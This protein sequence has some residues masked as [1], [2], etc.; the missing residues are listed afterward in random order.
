VTPGKSVIALPVALLGASPLPRQFQL[1]PPPGTVP[2]P[3]H[4]ADFQNA[5]KVQVNLDGVV[6][7]SGQ[8]VGPNSGKAYEE[9]V[10][11]TTVPAHVASTVLAM[12]ESGEAIR[13]VVAWLEEN[14]KPRV[15]DRS[16]QVTARTAKILLAD[17]K[18][19]GEALLYEVAQ[20]YE[21]GPGIHVYR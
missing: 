5:Q 13:T 9:F 16:A 19:G 11:E 3:G 12:K 15:N 20:G 21:K 8:F 2:T 7:A 17:Y 18:R 6:F 4:L 1:P 14:S 10:A